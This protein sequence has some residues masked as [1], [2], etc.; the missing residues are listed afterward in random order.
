MCNCMG[1]IGD[2]QRVFHALSSGLCHIEVSATIQRQ[3]VCFFFFLKP[4]RRLMIK[5]LTNFF[6]SFS[7]AM[8][9]LY[10]AIEGSGA[11]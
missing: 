1:F 6:F 2:N 4:G 10:V 7:C 11:I 8:K 5:R 3:A 9:V